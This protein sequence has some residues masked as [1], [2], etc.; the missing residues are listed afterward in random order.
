MSEV[1]DAS[2]LYEAM[3]GKGSLWKPSQAVGVVLDDQDV[4]AQQISADRAAF[5]GQRHAAGLW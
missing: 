1:D 4:L 5:G 3:A 2:G